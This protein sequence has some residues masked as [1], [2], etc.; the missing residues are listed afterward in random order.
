MDEAAYDSNEW[1]ELAAMRL[2]RAENWEGPDS[3]SELSS[4]VLDDSRIKEL[5]SRLKIYLSPY[6]ALIHSLIWNEPLMSKVVIHLFYLSDSTTN[7]DVLEMLARFNDIKDKFKLTGVELIQKLNDWHKIAFTHLTEQNLSSIISD[8][9]I[10]NSCLKVNNEISAHILTTAT[11]YL[12]KIDQ[13]QWLEIFEDEESYDFKLLIFILKNHVMSSLPFRAIEPF[14]QLIKDVAEE[15]DLNQHHRELWKILFNAV[16]ITQISS[17]VKNVRD[18]FITK[19]DILPDQFLLLEETLRAAG[20]LEE[21]AGDVFRK[22]ITPLIHN[23]DCLDLITT[24][25]DFYLSLFS[26]AGDDRIHFIKEFRKTQE[27]RP[28]IEFISKFSNGLD[29][30]LADKIEI[31]E[32]LY[33][34]DAHSRD[35]TTKVKE[36]VEGRG[37]LHFLINNGIVDDDDPHPGVPK[38]LELKFKFDGKTYNHSYK[39][40][41]WLNIP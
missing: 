5:G 39:E 7:M 25:P 13:S 32:A 30:L 29:G 23:E 4:T 6:D 41:D 1:L 24:S 38:R 33:L 36:I 15:I 11:S 3:K 34:T 40:G 27:Q 14:K 20:G 10:Y 21:R 26:H 12:E 17:T 37:V 31:L 19:I 8:F 22:I 16:D 18:N 28:G 35:V 9:D 2:A